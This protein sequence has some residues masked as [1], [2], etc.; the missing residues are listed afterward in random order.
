MYVYV[1]MYVCMDVCLCVCG[2]ICTLATTYSRT[3]AGAMTCALN[4]AAAVTRKRP[5]AVAH[6]PAT[7]SASAPP[8]TMAADYATNATVRSL[9]GCYGDGPA[10]SNSVA[11][12]LS[13]RR[14]RCSQSVTTA[15]EVS[16]SLT[17]T[18]K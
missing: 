8:V 9:S 10:K 14:T 11:E 3:V 17:P 15:P 13:L 16:H 12:T 2:Q 6:T 1:C 18:I 5:A 7:T 4:A